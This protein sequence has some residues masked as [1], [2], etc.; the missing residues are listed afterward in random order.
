[1]LTVVQSFIRWKLIHPC[2]F[3][4]LGSGFLIGKKKPGN[5]V[6]FSLEPDLSEEE[7][8]R[9]LGHYTPPHMMKNKATRKLFVK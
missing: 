2:S 9:L 5:P 7:C 8:R 3:T 6:K 1:M 4:C